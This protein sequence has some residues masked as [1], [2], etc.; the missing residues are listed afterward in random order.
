MLTALARL[1]LRA[2]RRLAAVALVVFIALAVVG[3]PTA[4]LL[5]D[6]NSFQDPSSQSAR[7]ERAIQRATGDEFTPGVMA[8]VDA[9]PSSAKVAAVAHL[10]AGVPGVATVATPTGGHDSGLVSRDGR[11][12]IVAATLRSAPYPNDVVKAIQARLAGHDGVLLGGND[13]AQAQV[14][15]QATHDL[16]FA[17]L[18]A[19]P[20]LLILSV[21][22]FR[23]VAAVLPLAVGALAVVGAFAVLRVVNVALS[24]ST[25]SLNLV[26][27]LGLGLAID[28]CLLLVW[29]FREE[30]GADAS[31]E[32]AL[33][34]TMQT[35]G[36]TVMFSSV[37]VA[38]A[39]S[40]LLVFPQRFLVSMGVGGVAVALLAAAAA[41]LVVP[42]LLVLLAGR[43]GKV[44]P[45]P[46]GTGRW[47]RVAQAVMRRPALTATLTTGVL[48]LAALPALGTHWSGVDATVLPTSQSARVVSDRLA[49]RFPS[50]DLNALVIAVRAG[51][52]ARLAG[53]R[54]V[55]YADAVRDVPRVTHVGAPTYVGDG[56]WKL[57]A[58]LAGDPISSASQQTVE[59]IRAVP[60]SLRVLVGG[61]AADL[62]D[63]K[64][65]IAASVPVAL[66]V[67][68]ALTLIVLWLM[69]GSVV[70]PIKALLLN[71]LTAAAATGLLV[72]VFQD[73]RL[74][75]LLGY[76]SQHGIEQADFLVLATLVFALSTDYGVLL[77]TRIKEGHDRGLPDREAIAGGLE[78]TGRLVSAS[79]V[80]LAVA[81]GA[82]ATSQVVFLKEIG[83]GAVVA[84]LI[85]AFLV[86]AALVPSLMAL[87]G[88][89]NWWSP[90]PLRRLHDRFSDDATVERRLRP[91]LALDPQVR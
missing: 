68:A 24:L 83:I 74:Q 52:R 29:R 73:G 41:L 76:T 77:L 12:S 27:G 18:L 1:S 3:G 89:W 63:Q 57:S 42:S 19:F 81:L 35:A 16:G 30:L 25:F 4:G 13:V 43:I 59:R 2:P 51:G 5:K 36:R 71:A 37:T 78:R 49:A 31:V 44:R 34:T 62:R 9:P 8:L 53:A 10:I 14:N 86:R 38:A 23:G 82:F 6:R 72:F 87:L 7:A 21:L 47:Y 67:L 11:E 39:M 70:L 56:V 79:A 60:S 91:E 65:S 26:I 85:D 17:E 64:T 69:T 75:G 33:E 90:A 58:A 45:A 15:S 80:L 46:A 20:L 88:S 28:Y 55:A 54:V 48:L 84:V 22:I 50:Q 66:A 32:Q 40:S 61:Q